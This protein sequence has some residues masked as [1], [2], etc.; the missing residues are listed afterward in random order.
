[1]SIEL[2][3]V[4]SGYNLS[5]INNNFQ[6]IENYV[7]TS[8]LH[9]AETTVAG[10]A[11]MERD[12]DMDSHNILNGYVGDIPLS[13]IAEQTKN[14]SMALKD[15]GFGWVTLDSFQDGNTIEFW[16]QV[17]R[18]ELPDGDGEFYRWDGTLPKIVPAG[19]TPLTTGG[20][21][22][23]AWL[24]IGDASLRA[25]LKDLDDEFGDALIAV[26]QPLQSS[27]A[28]TQHD[29]NSDSIS[30]L[31]FGA[32]PTG[33]SDSTT[34]FQAALDACSDK[35]GL[36]GHGRK[37]RIPGGVYTISGPLT[38]TWRATDPSKDD[39]DTQRLTID[40]DGDGCTFINDVRASPGAVPLFTFDGG[41]TD[42]HL[43]L[44][45]YGFRVQRPNLDRL[46][47]GI[48][49]RN[50]SIMDIVNCSVQWFG[51]GVVFRD[52][53]QVK[54]DHTQIGANKIGLTA[55]RLSWTNPNVFDLRHVMLA[56]NS[57]GA[58]IFADGTNVKF[59]TCSFEGNG[60][61]RA[62]HST[63]QYD[64]GSDEGGTGMIVQNS[65]FEN[66]MV[67]A[68]IN[69]GG[70]SANSNVF[71]IESNTMQRTSIAR[72]CV[73]H[74]LLRQLNPAAIHRCHIRG[75]TF[76]W[77]GGY[78]HVP[79]DSSVVVNSAYT[80]V[81]EEGNKY[82]SAQLPVYS[83]TVAD[84]Y[85]NRVVCTASVSVSGTPSVIGYNVAS[86]A[87]T[88]TGVYTLQ[89][90]NALIDVSNLIVV[91]TSGAVVGY[92]HVY[93]FTTSSITIRTTDPTGAF[94]DFVPFNVIATGISL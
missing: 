61:D 48:L 93:G 59:D 56:A 24:S 87:R 2:E 83:P 78:V 38:Y 35:L 6:T 60:S 73:Q 36:V 8:L 31:D 11:K 39:A 82:Q 33:T 53:L 49:F 34:A 32:D 17:L 43:R 72:T 5:K 30:V 81:F 88:A 86:V 47:Q 79:G 75:N 64:G 7:N 77:G 20:L 76:R 54:I 37:L 18:W 70:S 65:Y 91:A 25:E 50:I 51:A 19:S 57:E 42:P 44:S 26:K 27:I 69:I 94:T 14:V 41:V 66:N 1:M 23:G 12:L 55:S 90:K 46:G 15:G 71:L 74:I 85:N 62:L 28:R 63:L 16:N 92:V 4:P 9:R 21:G 58:A 10:E 67:L 3:D 29:K 84:G 40:G 13:E 52:C 80:K 22:T 68:D 45:L 89:F